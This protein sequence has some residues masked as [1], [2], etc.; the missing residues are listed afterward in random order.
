MVGR[1]AF[2]T[3][4]ACEISYLQNPPKCTILA[5]KLL[6]IFTPLLRLFT[7]LSPIAVTV[8]YFLGFRYEPKKTEN[9][10]NRNFPPGW[11]R[12][13]WCPFYR[14]MWS[15][16]REMKGSPSIPP[17]HSRK[18]HPSGS[19]SPHPSQPVPTDRRT[20]G[21]ASRP[22]GGSIGHQEPEKPA[23]WCGKGDV[24]HKMYSHSVGSS[25]FWFGFA[26]PS[27]KV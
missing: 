16:V 14:K 24:V 4:L 20:L 10:V 1:G 25:F 3:R 23:S 17:E 11:V 13:P 2:S 15:M 7:P 26:S 21:P 22:I 18:F 12:I 6:R 19:E 5:V 27:R 9:N 8:Y